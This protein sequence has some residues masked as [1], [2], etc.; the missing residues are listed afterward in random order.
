MGDR[1]VVRPASEGEF[2]DCI[3]IARAS[4]PSLHERPSIFH[5]FTKH[6]SSTTLVAVAPGGQIVGFVLGF[7]SQSQPDTGYIH[8]VCTEVGWQ[9]R[10]VASELYAGVFDAFRRLGCARARCIVDPANVASL[11][12]HRRQGFAVSSDGGAGP[13]GITKDY[14]GPGLSMVELERRL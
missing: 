14:N 12:F 2:G 11:A 4:F 9:G 7:R 8:L 3:A 13:D 6:F 5:I 10:S 1:I